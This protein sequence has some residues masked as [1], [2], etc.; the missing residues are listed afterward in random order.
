MLFWSRDAIGRARPD[1]SPALAL[2]KQIASGG[3]EVLI[4][5]MPPDSGGSNGSRHLAPPLPPA[6]TPCSLPTIAVPTRPLASAAQSE[7]HSCSPWG[8]R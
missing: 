1:D 4:L 3:R 6:Q 8:L 7:L 5:L 2:V